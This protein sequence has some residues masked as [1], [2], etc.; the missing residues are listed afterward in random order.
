MSKKSNKALVLLSGGL[1]SSVVLSVCQD[2][3]YDIYAISF[4]YGQRHKVELEYA[5]F[6]ATFFNCISHEVFKMEFYG[7]SALTDDIKVPK[8]RDSHSM[9]KDIPVTY[10]PSRN[11]VFL[12]FASGYAECHDI[13]NIFIGVNAIDYSGYPD[14]RKN[15]IDNFE[16]LINKSTKKGL[17]GSKFKINTPLINLSKKDIIKL[18]HK[19]GVD[20]SMTS[21]CYSPKLKKNCGVCDSCLLRKQGFEE[22]GLRD[23][24][25]I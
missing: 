10:V 14:C 16:K 23:P 2:K 12:S 11:I 21:S 4:D 15:F 18:G 13:D 8:N 1:D 9:S 25:R 22:A 6:Q 3:G 19:N 7:G 20:F 24:A 17:E 5:K